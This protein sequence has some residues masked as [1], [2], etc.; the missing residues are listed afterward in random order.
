VILVVRLAVEATSAV[1]AS[2]YATWPARAVAAG[3]AVLLA[4]G[5]LHLTGVTLGLRPRVTAMLAGTERPSSGPRYSYPGVPR[6]GDMKIEPE[7]IK[8]IEGILAN[9]APSDKIFQHIGYMDGGEVYFL[10][11][12]VNPTRFDVL[13]EIVTTGRQHQAFEEAEADPPK[14][15][16]GEDWGMTGPELNQYMKDHYH[17]IGDYGGFKLMGRND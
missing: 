7:Y 6:A 2:R 1:Y 14:L 3:T 4:V 12:R 16:V 10:A 5:S 13:T 9:S 8:L 17:L 15:T 11:D